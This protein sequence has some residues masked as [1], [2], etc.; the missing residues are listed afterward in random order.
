MNYF[1]HPLLSLVLFGQFILMQLVD[2]IPTFYPP[3]L[4][5]KL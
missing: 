5:G 4:L 3:P 1:F 2:F